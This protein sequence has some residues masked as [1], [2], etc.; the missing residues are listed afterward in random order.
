[1]SIQRN[2]TAGNFFASARNPGRYSTQVSHHS[3]QRHI[4]TA[5][6][7]SIHAIAGMT[8]LVAVAWVMGEDRRR[9]PWRAVGAGIA[10]EL[11]LAVIFLKSAVGNSAFMAFND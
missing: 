6:P 2:W 3:A 1:M 8:G 10:L 4:T 11:V 5:M 9:V 7:D